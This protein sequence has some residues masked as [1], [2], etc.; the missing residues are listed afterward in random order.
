M[1]NAL[2]INDSDLLAQHRENIIASLSH[3]LEVARAT[4]NTQLIALLEQ[5]Q[6]Q[7]KA[8]VTFGKA[9]SLSAFSNRVKRWWSEIIN[10]IENSNKLSV[11][12][13]VDET[14][15]VWWYAY[16]PCTG[17]TLHAETETEVMQWIEDNRLGR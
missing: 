8:Q 14:G 11:E 4:H 5:E 10:A 13:V 7:L 12:Q 1:A 2:H 3:R 17:K 16:D 15:S 9:G 6:R